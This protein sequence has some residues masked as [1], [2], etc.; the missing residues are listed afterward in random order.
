MSQELIYTSA[1]RGLKPGSRGF[2]TVLGTRG[3]SAPL[4]AALESLS[5]Y[6]AVFPP[7]DPRVSENPV[8]FSH[9]QLAVAG[10]SYSVLSR[11]SDYGLDYSQ[12]ANKI[13]HHLVLDRKEHVSGGPAAVLG[14]PGAVESTWSGEP[15][16]IP[17]GRTVTAKSAPPAICRAWRQATGDAGW[18]GVLA[19]S[20][21]AD[22]G[23]QAYLVVTPGM[24]VLPLIAEAI[25]LLPENARWNVTF[26]TYF[27]SLPPGATCQWRCVLAGS[28]EAQQS[29]RFV[30]ALRIDLTQPMPRA[31]GGALVEQART[32]Q[33]AAAA[34]DASASPP[35]SVQSTVQHPV[36][37]AGP[38]LVPLDGGGPG[39][40]HVSGGPPPPPRK[41]TRTL[42]DVPDFPSRRWLRPGILAV[43]MSL[44][45]GSVVAGVYRWWSEDGLGRAVA[46]VGDDVEAGKGQQTLPHP[47]TPKTRKSTSPK[48]PREDP[49]ENGP[50]RDKISTLAPPVDEIVSGD[51]GDIGAED[52]SALPMKP[53]NP[54]ETSSEPANEKSGN[55]APETPAEPNESGPILH[56]ASL[57]AAEGEILELTVNENSDPPIKLLV[58]HAFKNVLK[59]VPDE[60]DPSRLIVK[61]FA[62]SVWNDLAWFEGTQS[63]KNKMSLSFE[64]KDNSETSRNKLPW[65]AVRVGAEQPQYLVLQDE[66]GELNRNLKN[67]KIRWT[68]KADVLSS[69]LDSIAIHAVIHL[70]ANG[71]PFE[72]ESVSNDQHSD[73]SP[74]ILLIRSDE[75]EQRI[76]RYTGIAPLRRSEHESNASKPTAENIIREL[77]N[78]T[79]RMKVEIGH[80][81]QQISISLL[82]TTEFFSA[83]KDYF[84][85]VLCTPVTETL[86]RKD[87]DLVP[88][89]PQN[90]PFRPT[91]DILLGDKNY[92]RNIRSEVEKW[93]NIW[94]ERRKN[95]KDEEDIQFYEEHE[96][97]L[98]AIAG[99]GNVGG[100]L[101]HLMQQAKQ[102]HSLEESLDSAAITS[103]H[104]YYIVENPKDPGETLEIPIIKIPP[105]PKPAKPEP[106][107]TK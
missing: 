70:E 24:D 83:I 77:E 80:D 105:E 103:A 65:C 11:I 26:S 99:D 54:G 97:R 51:D 100:K 17:A 68:P 76:L 79:I 14:Q 46:D 19:E 13:A 95:V 33:V 82:S 52:D 25:H 40:R 104:I 73:S 45:L 28:P 31:T 22:P 96:E 5:G 35:T 71:S 20:I 66:H 43:V 38:A 93:R 4:A 61:Y 48:P 106:A 85:V 69:H 53:S 64:W 50:Q 30:Q 10:K 16:V 84:N 21:L 102:I 7:G 89:L 87:K 18:A 98:L 32:G 74:R 44:M 8:V 3:M 27:T 34:T 2:C 9:V 47:K 1:P 6:R 12:R 67:G 72:F 49:T 90:S 94:S 101:D 78:G 42:A 23:R 107:P 36:T 88:I 15:R 29:R 75:S 92:V 56:W 91:F 41:R 60:N 63:A 62:Y 57:P 86:T 37:V 58:P 39:A 59:G 81:R 55:S